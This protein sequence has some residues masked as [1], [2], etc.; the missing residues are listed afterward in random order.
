MYFSAVIPTFN[1][2]EALS[3][4]LEKL[5]NC[6]PAPQEILVHVDAGDLT[7]EPTLKPVFGN[8]VRWLHSKTRQGPGGG[9]NRLIREAKFPLIAS[10]DDD[11]WP[12]DPNY[13]QIASELFDAYPQA[14]VI[15]AQEFRR[16]AEPTSIDS[17]IR[18]ISCFQNCACLIRRD[19]FLQTRGYLPLRYAYGM[20]EADVALQLLDAGWKILDV[21]SLAV[22]HDTQLEHHN[23]VAINSSHISNTALLAYLRY[24]ISAWPL[25]MMQV[26][27]RVRYAASVGRWRGIPQGIWQIPYTIWQNRHH[28]QPVRP[29]TL[30]LSR[31]IAHR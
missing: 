2:P 5:L 23:T 11:S 16:N 29:E 6:D 30:K 18:E 21:P 19:A 13:F 12:L 25:G 20:E 28:R 7:T 26:L 27:N 3:Q 22:Y 4:C 1:R 9:R 8:Q 10:F 15:S 31:Q 24:P 17:D 14:A